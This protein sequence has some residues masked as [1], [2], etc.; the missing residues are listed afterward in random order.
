MPS[1]IEPE[2]ATQ[3]RVVQT[4]SR[5]FLVLLPPLAALVTGC[6]APRVAQQRL[7]S[8]PNMTFTESAVWGYDQKLAP[9]TEQGRGFAGGGSGAGC[10]SCR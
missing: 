6:S 5:A 10:T 3:T 2:A 1:G 9:Q 8:Q 4:R 7:V